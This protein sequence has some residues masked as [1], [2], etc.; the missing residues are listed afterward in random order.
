MA[1]RRTEKMQKRVADRRRSIIEAAGKLFA[2]EGYEAT[3][4][5]KIADEAGTSI[6][7]MYFYFP[8]KEELMINLISEIISDIWKHEFVPAHHD[9]K[10]DTWTYEAVDDYLKVHAFFADVILSRNMLNIARH[11]LFR[12]YILK[13]LEERARERYKLYGDFFEGLD[14]DM[15]LAY[16]LGGILNMFELMLAGDL[17]RS[18]HQ[19]GL[20]LARTKL[21]IRG[22]S[23]EIVSRVMRDVKAIVPLVV[24]RNAPSSNL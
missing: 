16:H 24:A 23:D 5:K 22:L 17:D 12:K 14:R 8:N 11:P 2:L 15:V 1:Y 9:L 3:T 7:N 4:M 10:I 13:F 6:G 21:E 20:F 18:P 19:A